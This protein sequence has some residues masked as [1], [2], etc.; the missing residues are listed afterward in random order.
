[1][2]GVSASVLPHYVAKAQVARKRELA[3]IHIAKKQLALGD[4][5]YQYLVQTIGGGPN[6]GALN[7][8]G[9]M[10]LIEQ[11]KKL[12]FK[13]QSKAKANA[14]ALAQEPSAAAAQPRSMADYPQA[15]KVRAL[16]LMLWHLGVVRDV[17]EAALE[18]YGKRIA[19]VD[20]LHWLNADQAHKL[21]ESLKKW[22]M[23]NL[24]ERCAELRMALR[25]APH[26]MAKLQEPPISIETQ[27]LLE[28]C[29]VPTAVGY[30]AWCDHYYALRQVA[31]GIA[32][33]TP[34]GGAP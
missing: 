9:R 4:A 12:G 18:A 24:P 33:S 7:R 20:R 16:W 25:N 13:V 15:K 22:A 34:E 31:L 5:D 32:A 27:L 6:A 26:I 28:R 2:T 21:I 30:D 19:R 10:R 1:M 8:A 3:I 23:R 29:R 14:P 11:F 17:S